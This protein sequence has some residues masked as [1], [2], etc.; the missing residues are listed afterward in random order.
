M[1]QISGTGKIEINGKDINTF[2]SAQPKETVSQLCFSN[3]YRLIHLNRKE[4]DI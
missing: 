1:I 3:F 4:N 2:E